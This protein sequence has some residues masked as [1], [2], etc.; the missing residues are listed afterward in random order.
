M[1][2]T[3]T[4]VPAAAQAPAGNQPPPITQNTTTET[5]PGLPTVE[6][7][8]GLFFVPTAD[9]LPA[10]KWSFSVFREAFD[11]RQGLTDVGNFGLTGAYGIGDRFE[12]FANWRMYRISRNMRAPL[13]TPQDQYFGGIAQE[14]P[15][16]RQSWSGN[17]AGPFTV[18]GKWAVIS[19]SRGDA[20]SLAPRLILTFPSPEESA[21]HDEYIGRIEAVGSREF[22]RAFEATGY[23]GGI[24]RG[25]TELVRVSDGVTWG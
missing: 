2:A 16:V 6:G 3:L 22:G 4:A 5:R 25:D 13:F 12:V 10:N 15:N 14:V 8:T 20:M 7:D 19:Q 9:V 23:I 18:G 17:K 11:M 1:L 21:G 24:L